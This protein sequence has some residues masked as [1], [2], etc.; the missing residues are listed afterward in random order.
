MKRVSIILL[1]AICGCTSHSSRVEADAA[2]QT[3]LHH[4]GVETKIAGPLPHGGKKELEYLAQGDRAKATA[5]LND[6]AFAFLVFVPDYKAIMHTKDGAVID[7]MKVEQLVF[8]AGS[9]VV[10]FKAR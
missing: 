8:V 3:V 7:M 5:L 9:K 1:L 6:G 4:L 2:R 10:A